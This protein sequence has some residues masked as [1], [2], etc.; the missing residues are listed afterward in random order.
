M[1]V[2]SALYQYACYSQLKVFSFFHPNFYIR[3]QVLKLHEYYFI[4]KCVPSEHIH[5]SAQL[6]RLRIGNFISIFLNQRVTLQNPIISIL[7]F[8]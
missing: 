8:N 5:H 4:S 7:E 3:I 2:I 6:G 1:L